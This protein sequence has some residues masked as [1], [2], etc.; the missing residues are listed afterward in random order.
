MKIEAANRLN[1]S[2]LLEAETLKDYIKRLKELGIK[3]LGS[4][5]YG[6]VFQH[7][8]DPNSVVKLLTR[9]DPL[10]EKY[11]DFC[12]DHSDN[13]YCPRILDV[14]KI[15]DI[16]DATNSE[17]MKDLRLVL[18][19]KLSPISKQ[20]YKKFGQYFSDLSM[21]YVRPPLNRWS[22]T[23]STEMDV[24][25]RL[26]TPGWWRGATLQSEDRDLSV[27]AKFLKVS[28]VG[29]LDLHFHNLMKRGSQIVVT[30][31]FVS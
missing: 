17:D 16:L 24:R 6:E 14:V 5:T 3:S 22:P 10:Y 21:P 7:P 13:K 18:M 29:D 20:E 15:D 31:P 8:T 23:I 2:A 4:G 9:K 28:R 12:V 30:D 11:I 25:A 19:E 27:L 1:A 26:Q